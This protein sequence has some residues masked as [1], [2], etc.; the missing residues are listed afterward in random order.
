MIIRVNPPM[1]GNT[2][3]PAISDF[4]GGPGPTLLQNRLAPMA[5][6]SIG[7]SVNPLA[8]GVPVVV[9]ITSSIPTAQK[10]AT[11]FEQGDLT[12]TG[13]LCTPAHYSASWG[14]TQS[15]LAL[16][17]KTVQGQVGAAAS[18]SNALWSDVAALLTSSNFPAA[19]IQAG[20]AF[21]NAELENALVAISK[22][23]QRNL[24]LTPT[25]SAKLALSNPLWREGG[26]SHGFDSVHT[27]S[28]FAGADAGTIGFA[29]GP[30]AIAMVSGP[31]APEIYNPTLAAETF[32]L[33]VGLVVVRN[34]WMNLPA[35]VV[36]HCLGMMAGFAVG[37]PGGGVLIKA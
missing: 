10:N 13:T 5:A 36:W 1:A 34:T 12:V 18:I 29:C 9:P 14:M 7:Q 33:P 11:S 22:S 16:G 2:V 21:G 26:P 32:T 24:L 8:R 28:S 20:P 6:F 3:S 25:Y 35:R 31:P 37:D 17:F 30:S 4:L 19:P 27:V 15:E 23:P